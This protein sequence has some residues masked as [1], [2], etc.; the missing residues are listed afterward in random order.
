[1]RIPRRIIQ[2]GKSS[3]L[4]LAARA[5]VAN[6]RLLNPDFEYCF[7]D[8][9][10]VEAFIDTHFAQ[11]RKVV[12]AFPVRIQRYDFFRYLAIYHL[13]GFYFD[14]D[15]FLAASLDDL[16]DHGCVL[17]FEELTVQPFFRRERNLDWEVGN[18]AFGA[19]PGHPFLGE[20]IRNCVR[21]QQEPAWLE[22]MLAPIPRWF[23]DDFYVFDTTGPGLV[24][25]TLA[26]YRDAA[27]DV[28]VLFPD[29][30]LDERSWHCFGSYGV[31]LQDGTWRSR[32]GLLH[33]KLRSYWETRARRQ[34]MTESRR[35]GKTRSL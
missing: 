28:K 12:D 15:V 1:M 9:A 21:A 7:F 23:R 34:C 6:V 16:L 10:Q 4:P 18:Y 29:D 35:L 3:D 30:V 13:G 2:T 27:R 32:K 11:Y 8:D 19:A 25:R 24:T 33:R 26:E 14:L 5:A 20:V 22:P 17:P 31:H